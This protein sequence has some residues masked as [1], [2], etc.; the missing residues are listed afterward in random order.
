MGWE[1]LGQA[2]AQAEWRSGNTDPSQ[3]ILPHTLGVGLGWTD[4]PLTP[5]MDAFVQWT[6]CTVVPGGP[7]LI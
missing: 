4:S 7:D 2:G 6:S 3:V 5:L 1:S